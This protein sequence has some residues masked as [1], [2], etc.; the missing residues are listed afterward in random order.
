MVVV[1]IVSNVSYILLNI[2]NGLLIVIDNYE[3]FDQVFEIICI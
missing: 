1:Q 3:K 2:A